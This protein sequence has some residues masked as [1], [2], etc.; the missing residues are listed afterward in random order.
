[1]PVVAA[2]VARGHGDRPRR[3]RTCAGANAGG[4]AGG[5]ESP[6]EANG[7]PAPGRSTGRPGSDPRGPASP[8]SGGA[9]DARDGSP[10]R[11]PRRRRRPGALP[12]LRRPNPRVGPA[13]ESRR[14]LRTD[15]HSLRGRSGHRMAAAPRPADEHDP[16]Q[17]AGRPLRSPAVRSPRRSTCSS[18]AP[19]ATG[20]PST[21]TPVGRYFVSDRVPFPAGSTY[22]TFAFGLSGIQTHLPAGWTGGRPARDPRHER[23][24]VDR[25][26]GELQV[27]SGLRT[28]PG[29]AATAPAG[30]A[31]PCH[32]AR[33]T[34]QGERRSPFLHQHADVA[35]A[36]EHRE[37]R[38]LG[39]P[40]EHEL[41]RLSPTARLRTS[42]VFSQSAGAEGSR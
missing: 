4:P 39:L 10:R 5:A 21:P 31:H 37:R 25:T 16:D 35:L 29:P 9:R 33:R 19:A 12:L 24:F 28:G 18:R 3:T 26:L 7:V 30:S 41:I 20:A 1:M 38:D 8:R 11:R 2:L 36:S 6:S 42:T 13:R 22:G 15:P 14:P 17:R 34:V 27:P 32:P 23:A 40:P